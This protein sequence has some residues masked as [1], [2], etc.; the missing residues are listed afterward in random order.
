[1]LPNFRNAFAWVTI[2]IVHAYLNTMCLC[3][4]FI[5]A[6][7][8][9]LV[10]RRCNYRS[11]FGHCSTTYAGSLHKHPQNALSSRY[12]NAGIDED[13]ENVGGD[14]EGESN[15]LLGDGNQKDK[16]NSYYSE[17]P[18]VFIPGMKGSHLSFMDE[19][20]GED[21]SQTSNVKLIR[22]NANKRVWLS[23]GNLINFPPKPDYCAERSLALP[24]TYTERNGTVYQDRGPLRPDGVVESI[25]EFG[26][27]MKSGDLNNSG[28]K[29][30]TPSLEL[31]PFYGHAVQHILNEDLSKRPNAACFTYDW[32]RSLEDLTQELEEFCETKFPGKPVQVV[33][34]SMGGLLAFGAM[35]RNPDKF[36]PG[37]IFA[38]VPFG[39]GIQYFQV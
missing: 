23:F 16:P 2:M 9:L 25:I 29:A 8:T 5:N 15:T 12:S 11:A 35:R 34:H 28:G 30:A 39:T 17:V 19:N 4:A 10:S 22:E 13:D 20:Q 21:D 18:L 1:M 6:P 14:D 37:G 3:S 27:N 38:G 26:K 33:A 31:F 36:A 7:S 24:L 32:R